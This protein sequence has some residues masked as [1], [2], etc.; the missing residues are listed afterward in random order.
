MNCYGKDHLAGHLA[1]LLAKMFVDWRAS[2]GNVA[3]SENL[4]AQHVREGRAEA[5][6]AGSRR[7]VEA[8]CTAQKQGK[9]Y[10]RHGFE[11]HAKAPPPPPGRP[12]KG[13]VF[14]LT[15]GSRASA[16]LDFAD[17]LLAMPATTHVGRPTHA[18]SVYMESR[19]IDLPSGSAELGFAQKVY[20]GRPRGENLP[21]APKPGH[22]YEADIR[23]T[24]ALERWILALPAEH[25]SR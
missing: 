17:M 18:D 12:V 10:W 14:L 21:Y 1:P 2:P 6:I 25:A 4:V 22:R 20:R 23:D 24:P 15:D 13:R 11:E 3:Y 5:S 9:R 7:M 16:C 8:M 19:H